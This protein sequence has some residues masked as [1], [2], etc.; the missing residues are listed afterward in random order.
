VNNKLTNAKTGEVM[1]VE[2]I[3][4]GNIFEKVILAYKERLARLGIELTYRVLDDA[5]YINRLRKFDFDLIITGFPQSLSPGNEQRNFWGSEA[6]SRPE[7]RNLAG[8]KNPVVDALIDKIIFATD[9]PHLIA[10]SQ[11]LD[12]VLLWNH[13]MV[14][15]W[16]APVERT[17]YWDR[18]GHPDPLPRYDDG[19]PDAWWFDAAHAAKTG[20]AKN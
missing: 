1:R 6:A 4:A 19:F 14:P 5:Q 16:Y 11:A 17:A 7:S 15:T 20:K 3:D 18:F 12:R 13:Y 9:R 2:Y 8:I 10:A